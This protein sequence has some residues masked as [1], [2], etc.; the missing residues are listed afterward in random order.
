MPDEAEHVAAYREALLRVG[1]GRLT[2]RTFDFGSDKATPGAAG[3]EANPALGRRSLRWCF[4]HPDVFR[5][6]LRALLRV[7]AEGDVRIMLPMVGRPGGRPA[8]AGAARRGA[9]ANSRG[10]ACRTIRPCGWER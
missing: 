2:I 9:R 8:G 3:D 5:P 10:R 6:Q 7:A 4:G 1:S